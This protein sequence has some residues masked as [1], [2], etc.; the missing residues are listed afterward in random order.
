MLGRAGLGSFLR[1]PLLPRD[2]MQAVL[3]LMTVYFAFI[4][5]LQVSDPRGVVG[6]AFRLAFGQSCEWTTEEC[7][8]VLLDQVPLAM[9]YMGVATML[10]LGAML[11]AL[12]EFMKSGGYKLPYYVQ[13]VA[14]LAVVADAARAGAAL[15]AFTIIGAFIYIAPV[16]VAAAGTAWLQ[17]HWAR[18]R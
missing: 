13:L 17:R 1:T 8:L 11:A 18:R 9:A 3:G 5:V 7:T 15:N 6:Y 10:L 2:W 4:A 14:W 16:L 12:M